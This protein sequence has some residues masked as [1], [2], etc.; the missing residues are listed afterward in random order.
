MALQNIKEAFS[1]KPKT[2]QP[3]NVE[4][5]IGLLSFSRPWPK[6][7]SPVPTNEEAQKHLQRATELGMRWFDSGGTSYDS[8]DSDG[9]YRS[10]E[11]RLGQFLSGLRRDQRKEIMVTTKFGWYYDPSRPERPYYED[12]RL[13]PA[14]K[15]INKSIKRLDGPPDILF[16]QKTTPEELKK[17][18]K[19][20]AIGTAL[21]YAKLRGVKYIGAT[22]DV[23]G[24]SLEAAQIIA[25]RRTFSHM[26]ISFNEA[27]YQQDERWIKVIQEAQ[28]RGKT[29]IINR[30]FQQGGAV[31][32]TQDKQEKA[33]AAFHFIMDKLVPNQHAVILT[34]TTNHLDENVQAFREASIRRTAN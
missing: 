4:L 24:E 5:G 29:V 34:G 32:N 14:I 1:R 21:F 13:I 28:R 25:R 2:K 20:L 30:A 6:S 3:Q 8:V 27:I 15:S 16:V 23:N 12:H 33:I 31:A 26:Q 10:S 19:R 11:E 7:D 9:T 17:P 22:P 18:I